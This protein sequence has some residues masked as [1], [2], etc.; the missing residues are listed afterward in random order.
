MVV[1][2]FVD[3]GSVQHRYLGDDSVQ[4]G[5]KSG[6]WRMVCKTPGMVVKTWIKMKVQ[7]DVVRLNELCWYTVDS[8]RFMR[9]LWGCVAAG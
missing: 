9:S 7:D 4:Y 5:H 2:N 6:C 8:T 3:G 1:S